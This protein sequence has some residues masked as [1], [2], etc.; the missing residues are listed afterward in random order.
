[1]NYRINK[2]L[3]QSLLALAKDA[4][5][6][7]TIAEYDD[8]IAEIT[9]KDH[10]RVQDSSYRVGFEPGIK[11]GSE[12]LGAEGEE[13]DITEKQKN[14][15]IANL[16]TVIGMHNTA[17]AKKIEES[18]TE[19]KKNHD[20]N[21]AKDKGE[22]KPEVYTDAK[23]FQVKELT[24]DEKHLTAVLTDI[25]S[26]QA[27][28]DLDKAKEGNKEAIAKMNKVDKIEE[29]FA[30][31][32]DAGFSIA[33]IKILIPGITGE[34]VVANKPADEAIEAYATAIK[35]V[36]DLA[37]DSQEV[38]DKIQQLNNAQQAAAATKDDT[39]TATADEAKKALLAAVDAEDD[40][41]AVV[42]YNTTVKTFNET[43]N[44][45]EAPGR[46]A[47][48]NL[49]T[50][51]L[52]STITVQSLGQHGFTELAKDVYLSTKAK[53]GDNV[54]STELSEKN[55]QDICN[56]IVTHLVKEMS[57]E[58]VLREFNE[59]YLESTLHG[60][61]LGP[62]LTKINWSEADL[63]YLQNATIQAQYDAKTNG[64]KEALQKAGKGNDQEEEIAAAETALKS[65][66]DVNPQGMRTNAS[67]EERMKNI[68]FMLS[69]SGFT[70]ENTL[71]I[72]NQP[73]VEK[74]FKGVEA[75][76]KAEKSFENSY[77]AMAYYPVKKA[78]YGTGRGIKGAYN[79]IYNL[80]ARIGNFVKSYTWDPLSKAWNKSDGKKLSTTPISTANTNK[81]TAAS[82]NTNSTNKK[83]RVEAEQEIVSD[84][85]NDDSDNITNTGEDNA[86]KTKAVVSVV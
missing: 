78:W 44:I 45:Q 2:D 53:D 73:A 83:A 37:D 6:D 29:K 30:A 11:L 43:K 58:D 13:A 12:G 7:D 77:K 67:S 10:L 26:F 25:N 5:Y 75:K 57:T 17:E 28:K 20:E 56:G 74:L 81:A 41:E 48:L 4:K 9:N 79:A 62:H 1:M 82:L 60:K 86:T 76:A 69:M 24:I 46:R 3:A 63:A 55:I 27:N 19:G 66:T 42:N 40:H 80:L 50:Q 70:A 65:H 39:A 8:T 54:T 15:I 68:A 32:K 84:Q 31:I 38:T 49:I 85:E 36:N 14:T 33:Q 64:L 23:I 52:G 18:N 51:L 16:Q 59:N 61:I 71:S 21:K 22:F 34:I 47:T 35:A 72:E